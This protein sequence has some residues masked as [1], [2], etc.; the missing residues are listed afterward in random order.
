MLANLFGKLF[1]GVAASTIARSVCLILA[2]FNQVMSA[3]G[4]PVLPIDNATVETWVSLTITIVVSV[5]D[6]WKNNS[7]TPNAIAAD[8]YKKQLDS[9]I[10]SK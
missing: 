3:T 7:F 9:G 4:H 5:I 2:L 10:I 6:W 1:S 8:D